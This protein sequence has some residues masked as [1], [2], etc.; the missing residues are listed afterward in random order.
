LQDQTG[1]YDYGFRQLDPTIGRW[2]VIDAM[3]EK[4]MHESPYNYA[5]N[6]PVNNIDLMGLTKQPQ[7]E[8]YFAGTE[9]FTPGGWYHPGGSGSDGINFKYGGPSGKDVD[10]YYAS[11][12]EEQRKNMSFYDWYFNKNQENLIGL[13]HI[14]SGSDG[15]A[16]AFVI[17]GLGV[18]SVNEKITV[19]ELN[20]K[21]TG[22]F[23]T[24]SNE[25]PLEVNKERVDYWTTLG[26]IFAAEDI[27]NN[28]IFKGHIKYTTTGGVLRNIADVKS[29]RALE[30]ASNSKLIK[31]LGNVGTG[32]MTG[33]ALFNISDALIN[34]TKVNKYDISDAV[35]GGVGLTV[36]VISMWTPVGWIGTAVG[37]GVAIYSGVRTVQEFYK[38]FDK[39]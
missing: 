21:I 10:R 36:W 29:I 7:Q 12:T 24:N 37:A 14:C 30:F 4:F 32:L 31:N 27:Y 26:G 38:Y 22:W 33:V 23:T 1:N 20:A 6:N 8:S 19:E 25:S 16:T 13:G 11:T 18:F 17:Y 3:S 35:V 2:Y 34:N 28:F 9:F 15:Y 5:G 39:L